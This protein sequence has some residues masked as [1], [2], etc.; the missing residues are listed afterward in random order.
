MLWQLQQNRWLRGQERE[1]GDSWVWPRSRRC[2]PGTS[3]PSRVLPGDCSWGVPYLLRPLTGVVH[4]FRGQAGGASKGL[5]I[6]KRALRF[7][8]FATG[9][10]PG[11]LLSEIWP[12]PSCVRSGIRPQPDCWFCVEGSGD[13]SGSSRL[14]PKAPSNLT[15]S[16][17]SL[18]PQ[19][20]CSWT[21]PR[22]LGLESQGAP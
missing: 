9:L 21:S 11:G 22:A 8:P 18:R 19:P 2:G 6:S 20:C 17:G 1:S 4:G 16:L 15:L 3:R 7:G 13:R 14:G 5:G 12:S 10:V